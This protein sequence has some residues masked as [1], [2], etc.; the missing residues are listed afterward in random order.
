MEGFYTSLKDVFYLQPTGSDSRGELFEKR[1]GPTAVVKGITFEARANY[2]KMAQI[3]AGYTL[4]SSKFDKAVTHFD[5]DP[6][7]KREFLRSPNQ[8]GYAILTIKP[9]NNISASLSAIYTGSMLLEKFSPN[10][11]W[12]PNEYRS[13]P[14]LTELSLKIGNTVPVD[15]LS[16]GVEVF[17]GIKN[18]TNQFQSD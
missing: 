9:T 16:S 11:D 4:Q 18:I 1:N 8:Y 10:T 2:N 3:E 13:S 5:E 17:G 14:K 6:K 15:V 12:Y 7:D